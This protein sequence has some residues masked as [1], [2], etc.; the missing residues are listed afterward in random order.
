MKKEEKQKLSR[1][2]NEYIHQMIVSTKVHRAVRDLEEHNKDLMF[3]LAYLYEEL[4]EWQEKYYDLLKEKN[5]NH[6]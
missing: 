2:N 5:E 6:D 1:V 3:K 4:E